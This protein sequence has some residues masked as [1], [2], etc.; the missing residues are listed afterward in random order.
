MI[1][2]ATQGLENWDEVRTAWQVA[3]LGTVS[4][5][6]EVLGVHHATVIRHIDAL[7]RQIGTRLFQRHAKGYTPTEA[8]RDL[9][10][11]ADRAADQFAQLAARLRDLG[12]ELSGD[13]VV[14]T[15]AGIAEDLVPSLARFRAAH[16]RV[17]VRLLTDTRLYRLEY[18]EA[19]V[20]IRAGARP[21]APDNVVLPLAPMPMGIW[22]SREYAAVHGVPHDGADLGRHRFVAFEGDIERAPHQRWL[23]SAVPREAIVFRASDPAAVLAAVRSGVGLGFV[24]DPAAARCADLLPALPSRPEWASPLWLVTHVDLHRTPK[25]QALVQHLREAGAAWARG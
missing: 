24:A 23:A 5:A 12:S 25:V 4:A 16:P 8:G 22:A 10:A 13:L 11:V 6:A 1:T 2:P 3:R 17:L 15:I 9:L 19:H 18:G 21:E 14:T 7:E 20:A